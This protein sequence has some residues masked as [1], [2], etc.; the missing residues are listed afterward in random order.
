MVRVA[1]LPVRQD[2]DAGAQAAEGS[3]D[4]E[5]VLVGV[6]DVA[7]RQ[8]EGFAVGDVEDTGSGGSFGGTVGRSAPGAGFAL[9]E[10][11]DAGPPAASIHGKQRASAS[12]LNVIAVGGDGED[13]DKTGSS[14][15]GVGSR[16][17]SCH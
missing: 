5:T 3:C 7:V 16:R 15:W 12:L 4:L 14:G 8:V 9:R 2:D 6:L 13:V 11:E 10:V 1:T 17:L